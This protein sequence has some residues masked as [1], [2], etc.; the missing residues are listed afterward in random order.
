MECFLNQ[1]NSTKYKSLFYSKKAAINSA[2]QA[3]FSCPLM[4]IVQEKVTLSPLLAIASISF[5]K[6]SFLT[7]YLQEPDLENELCSNHNSNPF[8]HF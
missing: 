3:G 1:E 2:T 7:D 4:A 6:K 5:T 8:L